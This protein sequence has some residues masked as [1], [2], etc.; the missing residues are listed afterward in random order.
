MRGVAPSLLLLAVLGF[1]AQGVAAGAEPV[2]EGLAPS[3]SILSEY[4]NGTAPDPNPPPYSQLRYLERYDALADS[5]LRRDA[6]DAL[7]YLALDAED[8]QRYLSLG[9]ELR[10]RFESVHNARF[11]RGPAPDD[12]SYLWQRIALHADLHLDARLRVFVQGLSALQLGD[13]KNASAVNQNP[14]DLQ[15]A[16]VDYTL[17]EVSPQGA[18]ATLRAGRFAMSYGSGR[19]IATRAAPNVPLKFDGLQGIG[20]AGRARLYG[21][22]VRPGE[23]RKYRLD[24]E[25][26]GQTFWGLYAT[27][28]T[29]LAMPATVD[30]YYLGARYAEQR[31]LR[32][33]AGELRHTIGTRLSG[34]AGGWSY[35]WEPVLQFGHFGDQDILAWTLATDTGYRF[36]ALPWQ[37]RLGLKADIASGDSSGAGHRFHGFNP[38]FFKAGYFNDASLIKPTNIADLHPSLQF[39]PSKSLTATIAADLLWRTSLK[40]GVYGPSGNLQLR[41]GPDASPGSRAIGTTAEATLS[42]KL[43]RHWVLTG[44]YVHLFAS[45][46]VR[47]VGGQDVDYLAAWA[48]LI[49]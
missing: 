12:V 28:P 15:Q 31:Y 41:P 36:T 29:G 42:W 27:A 38:L 2:P 16:F 10:E 40:D 44:A 22:L 30:L 9:G 5:R 7:K 18:R 37:P 47:A 20:V 24:G 11:G 34:E 26:D 45:D 6:F 17:G 43:D 49:W 23:E 13:Q 32:G 8:P 35:D 14:I 39:L 3:E 33:R 25:N 21:F 19:L 4:G 1:S 46:S 48:S